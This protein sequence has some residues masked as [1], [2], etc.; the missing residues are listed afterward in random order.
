[1]NHHANVAAA[2]GGKPPRPARRPWTSARKPV[3]SRAIS[4]PRT[5]RLA[6]TEKRKTDVEAAVKRLEEI[7]A[8]SGK[9]G[10]S[11]KSNAARAAINDAL[12]VMKEAEAVNART[13]AKQKFDEA[14]SKF[15]AATTALE[16]GKLADAQSLAIEAKAAAEA[17]K[18]AS[19]DLFEGRASQARL[20]ATA[21]RRLRRRHRGGGRRAFDHRGRGL[22]DDPPGVPAG[23]DR[24]RPGSVRRLQQRCEDRQR[25]LDFA[26]SHRGPHGL[27]GATT[28]RTSSSVSL[29]PRAVMS[30]LAEQGVAPGRMTAVGK[31][32]GEPVAENT[33]KS[34]RAQKPAHRDLVRLG[35]AGWR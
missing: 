23:Q 35:Q 5:L 2:C 24:D 15:R 21:P 26:L 16:G 31:G 1:M 3:Q 34:G 6:S 12:A 30:Y 20:R 14:E 17:A 33:S 29:G 8:L 28:T 11:E 32:E 7:I 13:H 27:E 9:L 19:A 22:A 10:D 4:T 18:A 25:V